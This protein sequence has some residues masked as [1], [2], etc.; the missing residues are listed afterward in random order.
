[1][2]DCLQ[3]EAKLR[4]AL[5]R[6]PTSLPVTY[7]W[8]LFQLMVGKQNGIRMSNVQYFEKDIYKKKV[9]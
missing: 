4:H 3:M 9:Q 8:Q 7:F 6:K 1:M 5:I 2:G